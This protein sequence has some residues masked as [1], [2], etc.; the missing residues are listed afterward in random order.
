MFPYIDAHENN[1]F[2]Q[3]LLEDLYTRDSMWVGA[4]R[5][6][7]YKMLWMREEKSKLPKD[8]GKVGGFCLHY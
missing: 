5:N 1:G 2:T 8:T 6:V 3:Q 7:Y 4:N